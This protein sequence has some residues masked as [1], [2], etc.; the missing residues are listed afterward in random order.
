M[1][2]EAHSRMAQKYYGE[3]FEGFHGFKFKQN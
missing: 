1:K 2:I 3:H